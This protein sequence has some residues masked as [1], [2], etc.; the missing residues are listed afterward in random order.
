MRLDDLNFHHLRYFWAVAHSG[1]L[2]RTAA[3]L[4][5]SQSALSSQIRQLESH[6][7][8]SLFERDGR[9][10]TLTEA[11]TLA[12]RYADQV[13]GS[14][15]EMLVALRGVRREA[16]PFRVGAVAT[17]SRNF[18]ESF[19][20]PLLRH[21][22]V[23]LSLESGALDGLLE[24]LEQL[25]L[26]VVL[27]NRP[28]T[29]GPGR[30]FRSRRIAR[31]PVSLVGSRSRK[32]FR[33][34]QSLSSVG[35]LLPGPASAVRA[36]FDALCEQH[37]LKVNVV[38]EVDDMAMMRLLA[39]DS[40]AFALVPSVV[41]RDELRDG[42]LHEHAVVP[43]VFETFYAITVKRTFPHPLL[44]TVLRQDEDELLAS[45]PVGGRR[46]VRGNDRPSLDRRRTRANRPRTGR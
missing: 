42:I 38:A 24:R 21:P 30:S 16:D 39:R 5:V 10:L 20:A 45:D 26:D 29:P 36:E 8:H 25:V 14:G 41:V 6:L 34:P 13:F 44:G 33:F 2:T 28:A 43:G 27:S 46:K 17:L 23:R 4:R 40:D 1:H 22:G 12:L 32:S 35:L 18:Q 3:Q 7:G 37:D 19:V 11:G 31:Q 9:R 15:A